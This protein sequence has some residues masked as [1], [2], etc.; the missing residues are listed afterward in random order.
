MNRRKFIKH[1]L[2]GVGA[3]IVTSN[4]IANELIPQ[5]AKPSIKF[6]SVGNQMTATIVSSEVPC[7]IG[8][9]P[10]DE[11]KLGFRQ[12]GDFCGFF[13]SSIHKSI[14]EMQFDKTASVSD[15]RVFECP[16][17]NKK[18]KIELRIDQLA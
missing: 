9:T 18:V 8:M 12:C 15:V 3:T 11:F 1:G 6:P 16:N 10:G 17:P 13:Y 7:T 14:M 4:V 5:A 2:V